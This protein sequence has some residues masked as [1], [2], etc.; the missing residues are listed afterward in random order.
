MKMQWVVVTAVAAIAATGCGVRSG[1]LRD[2]ATVNDFQYRMDVSGVQ[3]LRQ[4]SGSSSIGSVLC[5]IPLNNSLYKTAMANL[6]NDARLQ[7]NE[8][9]VNFRED[10]GITS[11]VGV[12]CNQ[13]LTLSADVVHLTP[14]GAKAPEQALPTV[15]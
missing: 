6:Y 13:N 15:P 7:P 3:Y 12:Y 2:S 11:Y 10:T 5:A 9:L 14:T 4:A 1:F 8:V